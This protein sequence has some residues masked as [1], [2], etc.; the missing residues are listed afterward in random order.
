MKKLLLTLIAVTAVSAHAEAPAKS[1]HVEEL[2]SITDASA[3]VDTMYNQLEVSLQ[4]MASQM[5]ISGSEQLVFDEYHAKMV[6]LMRTELNWEKIKDPIKAIYSE[7]FSDQQIKDMIAFY[8]TDTGKQTLEKMPVIVQESMAVSQEATA[9]IMPKMQEMVRQLAAD[10]E[11]LR[12]K[13]G[14]AAVEGKP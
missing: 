9:E 7:H 3:M 13:E 10:I 1:Q 14:A 5:G 11:Q 4:D 2:L 8:K 6:Q 12:T